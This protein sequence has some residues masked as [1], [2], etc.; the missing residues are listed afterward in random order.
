MIDMREMYIEELRELCLRRIEELRSL[1]S[2][3]NGVPKRMDNATADGVFAVIMEFMETLYGTDAPQIKALI[4]LREL[5][6]SSGYC[7]DR[8]ISSFAQSLLRVL[9][10]I[11]AEVESGLMTR[12]FQRRFRV[13]LEIWWAFAEVRDA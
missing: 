2:E 11:R 10:N 4:K 1:L 7:A 9:M 13:Y 3:P 6:N 12:V 5:S 8:L